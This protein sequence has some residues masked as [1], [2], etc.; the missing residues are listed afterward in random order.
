MVNSL[1]QKLIFRILL[2]TIHENFR[3]PLE[4]ILGA[5]LMP[6]I[7]YMIQKIFWNCKWQKKILDANFEYCDL[8]GSYCQEVLFF[9]CVEICL[10][11]RGL[12]P[13]VKGGLFPL[14]TYL[15]NPRPTSTPDFPSPTGGGGFEH[16]RLSR[17]LLVVE[18]NGKKTFESS[19]KIIT[20]LFQ[21]IFHLSQNWAKKWPNFRAFRDCQTSFRKT[22]IISGTII[23]RANP[24]TAFGRELNSNIFPVV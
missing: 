23:A 5:P 18:K 11:I 8:L 14:T 21:S 10:G 19:S 7:S 16:P 24:K 12:N 2:A 6:N 1:R 9:R 13:Y 3:G 15:F 17:L 20:K 4:K 22:S